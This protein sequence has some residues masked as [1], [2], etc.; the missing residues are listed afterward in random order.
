MNSIARQPLFTRENNEWHP[1]PPAMGPFGGLHGGVVSG[2]LTGEL[3]SLAYAKGHGSAI[4]AQVYLLRPAPLTAC[5]TRPSAVREGARVAVFKNELWANGKLQAKASMSFLKPL[6][7]GRPVRN[8]CESLHGNIPREILVNPEPMVPWRF[9]E[10][11]ITDRLATYVDAVDIRRD[12]HGTVWVR[13]KN[14]LFAHETPFATTM[15]FADFSTV[16]SVVESGT[17]PEAGGW[18]N[19]DLAM[20]LSRLPVGPW[21]GVKPR[22][23]W[24]PDGRGVTEAEIYDVYGRIGRSTQ[25]VVLASPPDAG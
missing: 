4:S 19:A 1:A 13:S 18:P 25:A 21:I 9:A 12:G 16:F 20:H 8:I 23:D 15:S 3:E 22:S 11:T 10:P 24:F 5:E 17:R 7:A 14:P 2:L 6:E